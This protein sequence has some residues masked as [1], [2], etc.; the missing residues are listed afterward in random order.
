MLVHLGKLLAF[1]LPACLCPSL[2]SFRMS[3]TNSSSAFAKTSV[4][5][6][7]FIAVTAR[8][9]KYHRDLISWE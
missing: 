1:L 9:L 7:A 2:G 5:T 3:G 4:A 8:G 6:A